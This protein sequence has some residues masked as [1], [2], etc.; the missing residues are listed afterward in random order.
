MRLFLRLASAYIYILGGGRLACM[1]AH[2]IIMQPKVDCPVW[3]SHARAFAVRA[4]MR[5]CVCVRA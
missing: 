3:S 4:Y 5:A 1:R 2:M